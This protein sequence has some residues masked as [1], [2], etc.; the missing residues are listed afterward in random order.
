MTGPSTHHRIVILGAGFGGLG[1]AI[2]L[3]QAGIDDFAVCERDGGVGGTW[4]A[5]T[6][7]GCQ[8][9]IPSHLYSF[10]FAPNPDW[11]RTY[12]EQPELRSYLRDCAE[13]FGVLPHIRFDCEVTWASWRE[14]DSLWHIQT[15]QGELTAEVMI[16]APGPLSEPRIP[17]LPGLADFAGNVFHTARWDH[18]QDLAG[19]RVAIVGTGASAIQVAPRIQPQVE[20]LTIFQRTPP[21]V[22]PHRDRPISSRERRLYRRFP[23]LQ[24]LVRATVYLSRELL[25]TGLVYRPGLMKLPERAARS[26]LAKQV[27]DPDLR[28]QL[29]PDYTIGCKR[30]LP[31][32]KWYPTLNQPNV[33]LVAS[34]V[35]EIR[36]GAL[37]AEDG[38]V[39]EADTII[40]ATGF[41]VTDIAA[42]ERIEGA[43]GKTLAEVWSGSP[44]GYLGT[45]IAGFP[46][47]FFLVGPNIGLGHNS[48]VFMIEAQINYVME[49]LRTTSKHGIKRL[50]V[51]RSVQDSY[52][53]ELQR[54]PSDYELST[55]VNHFPQRQETVPYP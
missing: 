47:L 18:R 42:A 43:G 21:W 12:P 49:A 29:T 52:N 37:V 11:T 28:E 33:E 8:C 14:E 31:S 30:I 10:S 3:K 46:N 7:P 48:I 20:R 9:D 2:R 13:R 34:G 6:Y 55:G 35:R 51:S 1:M 39:H 5:N 22:M 45:A 27:P 36:P 23:L 44:E 54:R 50:E 19:R 16:G 26:H 38:S 4:W 24:R 25:V 32:N 15:S 41:A 40:F 17:D 53:Q